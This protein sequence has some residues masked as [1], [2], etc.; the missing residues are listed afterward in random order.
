V[1]DLQDAVHE[2]FALY[3]DAV[4]FGGYTRLM[5]NFAPDAV[6]TMGSERFVGRDA[7]AAGELAVLRETA[8]I[9]SIE[10]SSAEHAH[11]EFRLDD[12]GRIGHCEMT[13]RGSELVD[14]LVSYE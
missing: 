5:A 13:W 4:N 2:H 8:T 3:N 9:I 6:L 1:V 10:Q 7:I 11:V 12:S 14:V